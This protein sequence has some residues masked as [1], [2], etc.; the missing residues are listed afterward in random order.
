MA[1]MTIGE[2]ARCVGIRPS[3]IRYYEAQG[4]LGPAQRSASEYRLYGPEAAST[5]RFVRRARELGFTVQQVR[6]LVHSS[7]TAPPCVACRE[8]IKQQLVQVEE[9]LRRLRARR[10]RLRRLACKPIPATSNAICPL[11]GEDSGDG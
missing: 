9:E 7:R 6:Q 4:I 10:S 11:I 3:A 8:L 1:L 5:I 2:L